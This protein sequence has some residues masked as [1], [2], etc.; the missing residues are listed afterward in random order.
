MTPWSTI[1]PKPRKTNIV[2]EPWYITYFWPC[3]RLCGGSPDAKGARPNVM[4]ITR[5]FASGDTLLSSHPGAVEWDTQSASC[6]IVDY[7]CLDMCVPVTFKPQG[8]KPR[9]ILS[10][11][12]DGTLL[13]ISFSSTTLAQKVFFSAERETPFLS[14]VDAMATLFPSRTAQKH[15]DL[16]RDVMAITPIKGRNSSGI[17]PFLFS[18]FFFFFFLILHTVVLKLDNIDSIHCE[19][20]LS[21]HTSLYIFS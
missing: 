11:L 15:R 10:L 19:N 13:M 21:G 7:P 8:K 12:R 9:Y 2:V 20:Y 16:P 3:C 4:A 14:P 17:C 1:L 18:L 5:F 6:A